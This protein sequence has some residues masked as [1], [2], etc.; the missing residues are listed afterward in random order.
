M[1][2]IIIFNFSFS[3]FTVITVIIGRRN[4]FYDNNDK[5]CLQEWGEQD[6]G[7]SDD[8]ILLSEPIE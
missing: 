5:I 8:T 4:Q 1:Y 6:D 2:F 3:T 7:N